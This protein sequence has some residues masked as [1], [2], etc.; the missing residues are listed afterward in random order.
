MTMYPLVDPLNETAKNRFNISYIFPFQRLVISNILRAAETKGFETDEYENDELSPHQIVLLPTGSG[1]SL[2]FMLP[3]F[4]LKGITLV[5]F[6]LLSL[7][8]DQLRRTDEVGIKTAI[9]RGGQGKEERKKIFSKCRTGDIKMILSNPETLLEE[10]VLRELKQTQIDHIV[11]DEAHT[12]SEWGDSFRPAYLELN[13]IIKTLNCPLIT[14]FTATASEHILYRIKEILFSGLTP[15]IVYGNPDRENIFYSVI[16]SDNPSFTL[17]K[18]IEQS[19][20]PLIIFTSSRTGA[21]LTSRMI[22]VSL[23]IN[24]TYFYHAGLEKEEKEKVEK[25]FFKSSKGILVATTAYGMGVDKSNIRT[26]IHLDLPATV[27]SYLQ[28]SGRAG[29]DR[30]PSKAIL[31]FHNKA[32]QKL[33]QMEEGLSKER[34][35]SMINYCQDETC[36]RRENLLSMLDSFP[37]ICNGCDVCEKT[38]QKEVFGSNIMEIVSSNKRRFTVREL[39]MILK[40]YKTPRMRNRFLHEVPGHSKFSHWKMECIKELIENLLKDKKLKLKKG[41]IGKQKLTTV[42]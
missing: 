28:E 24:E 20:K 39:S 38:I 34:F 15:N 36:C 30:N 19:K 40:G 21:E 9:L 35:R 27:E 29:R 14:A 25:W 22:R 8:T 31:I 32:F 7:I 12:V 13:S 23:R 1:K 41:G 10:T 16:Q 6:P 11:I 37:E 26:V 33:K 3:T 18:T 4:F 17:L 2:C 5:I 42:K